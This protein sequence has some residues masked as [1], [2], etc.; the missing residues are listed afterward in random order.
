GSQQAKRWK[1]NEGKSG[2][3]GC[4]SPDVPLG[5][6][7][8]ATMSRHEIVVE[9]SSPGPSPCDLGPEHDANV[10]IPPRIDVTPLTSMSCR[11]RP[12]RGPARYSRCGMIALRRRG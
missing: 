1:R 11:E 10:L 9:I 3:Q 5:C 7:H 6:S 2:I 12:A 4:P 8:R